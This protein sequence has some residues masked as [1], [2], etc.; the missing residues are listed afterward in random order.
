MATY[1]QENQYVCI[2]FH[3]SG[4]SSGKQTPHDEYKTIKIN[5]IYGKNY[6]IN[7]YV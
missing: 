5:N 6:I 2:D 4:A 1:K 3:L 7:K